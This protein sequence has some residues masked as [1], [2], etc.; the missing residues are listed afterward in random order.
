MNTGARRVAIILGVVVAV[1]VVLNL[2]AS[3][4]DHAV[5]DSEPSGVT[6]SSYATNEAGLAAYASLLSQYGHDVSVQRGSLAHSQLDPATTLVVVD[7]TEITTDDEA[8]LLEFVAAG[9]RL[10]I[11]G[12]APYYVRNL[13]DN[14][15]KWQASGVG[16]WNQI[17][18]SLGNL[19]AIGAQGTG[20]WTSTGSGRAVVGG[21]AESLV[22]VDHVGEG[23]IYMLADATP[24][25][26]QYVGN[27]DNAAF[28]LALAGTDHTGAPRPVVFAEGP[29]GYGQTT[30][31]AA[32]PSQWKAALFILLLAI[33][34]FVWSRARRFGPPDRAAR[35]LPPP[36][37]EYV[38][39]LSTTLE[40]TRDRVGALT[41]A[42]HWVREEI[43]RKAALRPNASDEEIAKAA[44]SFGARDDEVAA[45]LSPPVNDQEALALGRLIARIASDERSKA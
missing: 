13:R 10:I 44:R 12:D 21:P 37:A 42:Q 15:P 41:P 23:A 28:A 17:D 30:G 43:A 25:T 3:G 40:R 39:A 2:L 22:I 33:I 11:G 34:V 32:I 19:H 36:R 24:L 5:N 26:N 27:N 45:L 38:R 4:L 14:P 6:G 16:V 31:I 9:G 35:D 1:I 8:A 7:P 20:S 29:H 18:P